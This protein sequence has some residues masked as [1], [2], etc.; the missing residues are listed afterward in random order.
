M[1]NVNLEKIYAVIALFLIASCSQQK[2]AVYDRD[3]VLKE[4]E[5]ELNT[6]IPKL[7]EFDGIGFSHS[8][9]GTKRYTVYDLTDTTNAGRSQ[10]NN[11]SE[12]M[13]FKEGHFYHFS[14]VM[15]ST[16]YSFIAYLKY[17]E[18][19]T[20]K[21]VNCPGV[22]DDIDDVLEF[23]KQKKID[24]STINNIMNYRNFGRYVWMDNYAVEKVLCPDIKD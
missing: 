22:K 12:E 13:L 21:Y 20:F 8:K 24:L 1:Q 23:A 3:E 6:A 14:P 15:G 5:I 18:I 9:K 11:K 16:S 2:N 10:M 7:M 4:F 19:L 17:G